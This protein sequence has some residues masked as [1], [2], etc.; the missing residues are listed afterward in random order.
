M[1]VRNKILQISGRYYLPKETEEIITKNIKLLKHKDEDVP[2]DEKQW[3]ANMKRVVE[4]SMGIQRELEEVK[5]DTDFTDW[6]NYNFKNR[7]KTRPKELNKKYYIEHVQGK[8][9]T[10]LLAKPLEDPNLT[11]HEPDKGPGKPAEFRTMQSPSKGRRYKI[12]SQDYLNFA[13]FQ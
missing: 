1:N 11:F 4:L 12:R 5:Q 13:N 8:K 6:R 3:K 9:D 10:G 7:I 2:K